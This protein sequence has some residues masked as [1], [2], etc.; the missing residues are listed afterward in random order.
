MKINFLIKPFLFFSLAFTSCATSFK[1]EKQSVPESLSDLDNAR[2]EYAKQSMRKVIVDWNIQSQVVDNTCIVLFGDKHEWILN[3]PV[4]LVKDAVPTLNDPKI[5]FTMN[6]LSLPGTQVPYEKVSSSI[7]A[8]AHVLTPY[9]QKAQNLNFPPT[10]LAQK[11]ED[12]ISH[13]PGFPKEST[14]TEEILSIFIHEF[15]HVAQFT[16]PKISQFM[17]L[18]LE[19]KTFLDQTALIQFYSKNN[20]YQ[21]SIK[22]EYVLLSDYLINEKQYNKLSAKKAL[23]KWLVLYD[24]RMKNFSKDFSSDQPGQDL[25]TWDSF[26]T[27]VEGSARF[28]ESEFL[29]NPD[30]RGNSQNLISDPYFKNFS[31][32]KGNNYSSLPGANKN[33]GKKYYYSLGMHLAFILDIATEKKWRREAFEDKDWIVGKVRSL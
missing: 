28:V 22:K 17:D 19:Q 3:C 33:I 7:V 5:F 29:L 10:I 25:K 13:H 2:I 32:I 30:I 23:K 6:A 16:S 4:S 8:Q 9:Q 18:H 12:L 14:T 26:W 27:F 1:S 21:E 15:F 31:M 24:Q 11:L 20:T